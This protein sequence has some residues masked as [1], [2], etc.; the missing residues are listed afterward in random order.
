MQT[1]AVDELCL[2]LSFPI[3]S[4]FAVNCILEMNVS[5]VKVSRNRSRFCSRTQNESKHSRRSA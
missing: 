3:L 5:N 4:Y 2:Y 1:V